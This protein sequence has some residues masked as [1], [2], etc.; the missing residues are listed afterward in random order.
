MGLSEHPLTGRTRLS[1]SGDRQ[2]DHNLRGLRGIASAASSLGDGSGLGR[3]AAHE[4]GVDRRAVSESPP[5]GREVGVVH[6]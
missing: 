6:A 1:S 3:F 4:I 5:S 2:R